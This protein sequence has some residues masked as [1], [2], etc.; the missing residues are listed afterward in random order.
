MVQKNVIECKAMK[1]NHFSQYCNS[2]ASIKQEMSSILA[3]RSL[4]LMYSMGQTAV[5]S[6]PP[7]IHPADMANHGF[8]FFGF[9]DSAMV[10]SLLVIQTI[11][12]NGSRILLGG[13]KNG[14]FGQLQEE[15]EDS[16]SAFLWRIKSRRSGCLVLRC[17]LQVTSPPT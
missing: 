4:T 6:I 3:C 1:S 13:R 5:A 16:R 9:V 8:F 14:K 11:I 15:Q 10:I 17:V 7:A 12:M 2:V